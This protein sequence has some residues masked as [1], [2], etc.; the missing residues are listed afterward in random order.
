M[1]DTEFTL[2]DSQPRKEVAWVTK[3]NT[4]SGDFSLA[5]AKRRL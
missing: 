5:K 1:P 4:C 2:S 3:F